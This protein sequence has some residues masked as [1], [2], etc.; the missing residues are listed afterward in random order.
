[1][2]SAVGSV[3]RALTVYGRQ[4][5]YAER[6]AH[7]RTPKTVQVGAQDRVSI[8]PDARRAAAASLAAQV[9]TPTPAATVSI[10]SAGAA[11]QQ[12]V[13]PIKPIS[14]EDPRRAIR[15]ARMEVQ[16][17]SSATGDTPEKAAQA[18]TFDMT[19][20]AATASYTSAVAAAAG[21]LE[22]PIT[23]VREIT[24]EDPRKAIR[25]AA[26]EKSETEETPE[27]TGEASDEF[28]PMFPVRDKGGTES[29]RAP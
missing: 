22:Q 9:A 29:E 13:T 10:S 7:L 18:A 16:A 8:S 12:I 2:I 11:A 19:D 20:E 25:A 1:M 27:D 4:Q 23:P 24:Y 14:Y 17:A 5:F 21:N 28:T 15:A 6:S 26:R 3:Q